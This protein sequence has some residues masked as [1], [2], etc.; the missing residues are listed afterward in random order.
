MGFYW[1]SSLN[2]GNYYQVL[3]GFRGLRWVLMSFTEFYRVF[4]ALD[5][6]Y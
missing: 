6:F 1:V 3:P 5:E 2:L 4:V